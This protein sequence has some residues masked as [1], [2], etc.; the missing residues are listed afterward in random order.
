MDAFTGAGGNAIALAQTCN[1]VIAVDCSAERV[2]LARSNAAVYG[3]YDKVDFLCADFFRSWVNIEP[4]I[5]SA[6]LIHYTL[7]DG[8]KG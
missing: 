7:T 6:A 1:H 5:T 4:L 8:A 2:A 3:L